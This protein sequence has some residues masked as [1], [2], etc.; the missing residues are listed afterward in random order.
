[1]KGNLYNGPVAFLNIGI[2]PGR[3]ISIKSLA[4]GG[5]TLEPHYT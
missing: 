4:L 5:K 1:M 2:P 3:L